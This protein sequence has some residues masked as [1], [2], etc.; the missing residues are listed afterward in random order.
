M[1]RHC[2]RRGQGLPDEIQAR[3][4]PRCAAC[5]AGRVEH[6][7]VW[8]Q[9]QAVHSVPPARPSLGT[10]CRPMS[11]R[12]DTALLGLLTPSRRPSSRKA[13]LSGSPGLPERRR[14]HSKARTRRG[15][16]EHESGALPSI[17]AAVACRLC[18]PPSPPARAP[19]A[20]V[21]VCGAQRP[22]SRRSVKR[23]AAAAQSR[24]AV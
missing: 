8:G 19:A 13:L 21:G 12:K 6:F 14:P 10:D 5:R 3:A 22:A 2:P 15:T 9:T 20:G 1:T 24:G 23:P 7:G 4:L 11:S 18:P 16:R 17:A